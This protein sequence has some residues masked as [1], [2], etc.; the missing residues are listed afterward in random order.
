LV[1]SDLLKRFFVEVRCRGSG[2]NVQE[3]MRVTEV[4]PQSTVAVASSGDELLISGAMK[5][6]YTSRSSKY[7]LDLA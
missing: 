2:Y 4:H 3:I 1:R 6:L 5:K 7:V